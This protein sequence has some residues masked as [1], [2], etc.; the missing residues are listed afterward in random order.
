MIE[1]EAVVCPR[2]GKSGQPYAGRVCRACRN[3]QVVARRRAK[4]AEDPSWHEARKAID[5]ER[6]RARLTDPTYR[7]AV[8]ARNAATQTARDRRCHLKGNY[9]LTPD[10]FAALLAAQGDRCAICATA[11]PRGK[12]WCVDHDHG[13]GLVRGILCCACNRGLGLFKD[14]PA[15]LVAAAGYLR[16]KC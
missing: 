16:L 11:D 6:A 10:S 15:V 5:A 1:T 14:S 13:S 3:A 7:A 8:Y 12:G 9:G 4:R 2:C